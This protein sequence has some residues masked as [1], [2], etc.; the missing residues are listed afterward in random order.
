MESHLDIKRAGQSLCWSYLSADLTLPL[1][2]VRRM[3]HRWYTAAHARRHKRILLREKELQLDQAS[4]Q[5]A[6]DRWRERY[7]DEKLRPLV[8]PAVPLRSHT[9]LTPKIHSYVK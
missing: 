8:S 9:L 2:S 4:V 7:M 6:W 3:F 1:E 5:V